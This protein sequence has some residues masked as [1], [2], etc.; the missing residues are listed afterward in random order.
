[1]SMYTSHIVFVLLWL[2]IGTYCLH[3]HD[4]P[5][6]SY[7]QRF[8]QDDKRNSKKCRDRLNVFRRRTA[9]SALQEKL[10]YELYN[11]IEW[12]RGTDAVYQAS[13]T[14]NI[15]VPLRF[16]DMNATIN[17]PPI[18]SFTGPVNIIEYYWGLSGP[19]YTGDPMS[20]RVTGVEMT[21]ATC[22]NNTCSFQALINFKDFATNS[23]VSNYTHHGNVFF[24]SANKICGGQ[25]NFVN[26]A[27]QD[28]NSEDANTKW[29]ISHLTCTTTMA[30]CTGTNQQ[31]TS[32]ESCMSFMATRPYG[33]FY[34]TGEDT[35]IC[36]LLHTSLQRISPS[37]AA[38]HCPHSGPTG[39]GKCIPKDGS[40]YYSPV[41]TEYDACKDPRF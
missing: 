38:K 30:Q 6:V 26:A 1:M 40:F 11:N 33:G 31:Y 35:V 29:F 39:G 7:K 19:V 25:I 21:H 3:D 37:A 13:T 36:R 9:R 16:F 34:R 18:G 5:V 23:S 15:S 10:L 20:Q 24:N 41:N 14:G 12:P 27:W 22:W 17:L 2:M 28:A 4:T 8:I 32:Y